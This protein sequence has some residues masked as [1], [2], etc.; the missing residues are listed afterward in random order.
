MVQI[1][2]SKNSK[3]NL[4]RALSSSVRL[5]S[6]RSWARTNIIRMQELLGLL[7]K[8]I[9]RLF[10][11][12]FSCQLLQCVKHC[13]ISFTLSIIDFPDFCIYCMV[14]Q[15]LQALEQGSDNRTQVHRRFR[16]LCSLEHPQNASCM[17]ADDTTS[18][19]ISFGLRIPS[20]LRYQPFS[21]SG[22]GMDGQASWALFQI[23][24]W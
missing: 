20:S 3:K 11:T 23:I 17:H 22:R 4:N 15:H 5:S 8:S 21:S 14:S 7:Y 13:I 12:N 16:Q 18:W 9:L 10:L 6:N 24:D 19:V 1:Q 2:N